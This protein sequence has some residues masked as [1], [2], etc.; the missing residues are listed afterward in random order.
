MKHAPRTATLAELIERA[1]QVQRSPRLA[2]STEVSTRTLA[3]AL[4]QAATARD[5]TSGD[6]YDDPPITSQ[7]PNARGVPSAHAARAAAVDGC[8]QRPFVAAAPEASLVRAAP[9]RRVRGR[10]RRS[11]R[12][13]SGSLLVHTLARQNFFVL[14]DAAVNDR[15]RDVETQS[16]TPDQTAPLF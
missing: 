5:A 9:A 6:D 14:F 8:I 4:P 13:D 3:A 11:D 16:V 10:P 2:R 1:A 7:R 15:A 12:S